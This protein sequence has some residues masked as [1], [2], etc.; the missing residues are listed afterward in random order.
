MIL[1]Q[2]FFMQKPP[3]P[4]AELDL[5]Q[6]CSFYGCNQ[7]DFLPF[8]CD[9]CSR[10]Y[11]LDHRGRT[12]HGCADVGYLKDDEPRNHSHSFKCSLIDCDK[13]ELIQIAC[14]RCS[15][16]FCVA[17]RL[18][19]DHQCCASSNTSLAV[20]TVHTTV[21]TKVARPLKAMN[22]KQQSLAAKVALIKLK[23]KATG[24]DNVPLEFRVFFLIKRPEHK[25]D[26]LTF[27]SEKWT[28]GQLLDKAARVSD[29]INTNN[30]SLANRLVLR[31]FH[32]GIDL[33]PC[34]S[35]KTAVQEKTVL[36][37]STLELY[38]CSTVVPRNDHT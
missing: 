8:E 25:E 27:V 16:R 14:K 31:N 35:I 29:L 32:T 24:D 15:N 5:G 23:Q 6:H 37:G 18:P 17:H 21:H 12:A 33:D 28:F 38:Y 2:L 11:C 30:K 20:K 7:L 10:I 34:V 19:E 13:C 26:L 1:P 22:P 3:V 9:G 4:M 36:S